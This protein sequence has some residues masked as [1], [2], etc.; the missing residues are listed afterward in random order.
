MRE[1]RVAFTTDT[2]EALA[3]EH[4]EIIGDLREAF[5][6][7]P[8]DALVDRHVADILVLYEATRFLA[9]DARRKRRFVAMGATVGLGAM[10]AGAGAAAAT[11]NLPTGLQGVVAAATEPFGIDLPDGHTDVPIIEEPTP[12]DEGPAR[13]DESP[14]GAGQPGSG[15]A[16]RIDGDDPGRSETAPGH[17]DSEN[18]KPEAPPGLVDNPGHAPDVPP[19]TTPERP[20][21][22]GQSGGRAQPVPEASSPTVPPRDG[23]ASGKSR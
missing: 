14:S 9:I 5:L 6:A 12:S 19:S 8:S 3:A 4:P 22:P 7:A 21:A 1:A 10:L 23:A 20:S 11:G 15:A 2:E 17:S 16:P 13:A 18:N